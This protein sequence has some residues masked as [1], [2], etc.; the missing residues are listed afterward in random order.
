MQLLCGQAEKRV[1]IGDER[2]D[3][4]GHFYLF[5][6]LLYLVSKYL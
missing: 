5:L 6:L 1:S 2:T 4:L 3:N